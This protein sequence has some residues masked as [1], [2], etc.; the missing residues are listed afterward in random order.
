MTRTVSALLHALATFQPHDSWAEVDDLLAELWEHG[1]PIEALVPLFRFLERF[2]TDESAG[3]LMGLVHG[4]ETYPAYESE[5][6]DSLRRQPTEMTLLLLR[7]LANTGQST[8]AHVSVSTLYR[9]I[10]THPATPV[11]V[12]ELAHTFLQ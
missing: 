2:P 5:L 4:L 1:P 3:V 7:R 8:V 11:K 9:E 6:V 10:Q 12:Q